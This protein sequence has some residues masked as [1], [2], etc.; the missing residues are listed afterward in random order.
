MKKKTKK[1]LPPQPKSWK[2]LDLDQ[3]GG[4]G[5]YVLVQD[6]KNERMNAQ[7]DELLQEAD[8]HKKMSLEMYHRGTT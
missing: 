6:L 2:K 8:D 3:T 1:K 4:D 7:L 5:A